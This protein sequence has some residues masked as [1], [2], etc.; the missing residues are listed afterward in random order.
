MP[1]GR[2]PKPLELKDKAVSKH[3]ELPAPIEVAGELARKP[4]VTLGDAG[5]AFWEEVVELLGD[6]VL[7]PI[8]RAALQ[9]MC[10][11]LDRAHEAARLLEDQ[12]LVSK[13][14]TGQMAEHPA[15]KIEARAH[16]MLLRFAAELGATPTARARIA[17]A[18]E[19]ERKEDEF[20]EVV[21]EL[22]EDAEID[23]GE[24]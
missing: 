4:P 21:G 23:P 3:G 24:L 18:K 11:Q 12:G 19:K 17:A 15:I 20:E 5:T 2:K 10:V 1:R 6:K 8:D 13:G 22:V 16:A 9:A 14:S 7:K